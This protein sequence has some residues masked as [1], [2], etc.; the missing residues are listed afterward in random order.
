MFHQIMKE[1]EEEPTC[2]YSFKTFL[3]CLE[4]YLFLQK[5]ILRTTEG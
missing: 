1:K 4:N 5:L 3:F 2:F